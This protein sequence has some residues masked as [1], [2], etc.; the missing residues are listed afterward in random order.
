[1]VTFGALPTWTDNPAAGAPSRALTVTP[2]SFRSGEAS[3][4]AVD[5]PAQPAA[6]VT[7]RTHAGIDSRMTRRMCKDDAA[8]ICRKSLIAS[9]Y[10]M[11]D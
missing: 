6:A 11:V 1:V 2:S 9:G 5:E 10:V 3:D 4:G 7:M 8:E